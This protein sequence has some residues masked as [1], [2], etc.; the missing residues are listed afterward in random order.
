MHKKKDSFNVIE[1][2]CATWEF[3]LEF[4][5][6]I[7]ELRNHECLKQLVQGW[8]SD[9]VSLGN[10]FADSLL[11]HLYRG[12]LVFEGS[13]CAHAYKIYHLLIGNLYTSSERNINESRKLEYLESFIIQKCLL[14]SKI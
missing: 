7:Y 10:T 14:Q 1:I 13:I 11:Q 2:Y 3:I 8:F 9:A 5:K 12:R 4:S 6:T